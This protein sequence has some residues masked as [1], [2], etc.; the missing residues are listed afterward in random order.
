M[1]N[2]ASYQSFH[3][4]LMPAMIGCH[5][6]EGKIRSCAGVSGICISLWDP[7][8]LELLLVIKQHTIY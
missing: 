4:E 6:N 7:Q 2:N 3:A 8:P 1:P 5:P